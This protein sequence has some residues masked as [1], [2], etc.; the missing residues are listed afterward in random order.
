MGTYRLTISSGKQ[1]KLRSNWVDAQ[2]DLVFE[3]CIQLNLCKT[4]TQ[5]RQNKDFNDKW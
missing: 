3:E 2:S 5:N 4:A 1:K